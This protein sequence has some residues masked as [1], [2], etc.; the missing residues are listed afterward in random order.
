MTQLAQLSEAEIE[1]R[2]HVV[3]KT[4][5]QFLL[6]NYA[7]QA[8]PFS[9]QFN[10]GKEFFLTTLLAVQPDSGRLIFD[11][12][13]SPES[14]RRFVDSERNVFVARP[15][16]I[17]VQFSTGPASEVHFQGAPAFVVDL[18]KLL[19]RLQR[20]EQFRIETSLVRPLELFAR[21]PGGASLS[22]PAHDISVS[23][24]GLTA[25]AL[26]P[27][28]A[29]GVLL[30]GCR[31]ALPEETR[32]LFF[33]ASVR[34]CTELEPRTGYRQWRLGLQFEH[35][36]QSDEKRIQRYIIRIEHERREL[37]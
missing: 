37:A 19:L 26:P 16:G 13:G 32:A 31:F 21:L 30:E 11:C 18:P 27:G 6:A 14:N 25:S 22:L 20:R 24:I 7:K 3:S 8:A 23:G 35:L 1:D 5:I 12:S 28:L 2:F 36:A 33:A 4:A 34:H 10:A 29:R 15:G 17:Q 9:V